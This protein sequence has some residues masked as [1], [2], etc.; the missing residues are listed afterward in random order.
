M[1]RVGFAFRTKNRL[2]FAFWIE[3]DLPFEQVGICLLNRLEFKYFLKSDRFTFR[4]D[5]FMFY[6]NINIIYVAVWKCAYHLY[7]GPV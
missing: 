2:R 5:E 1:N 7:S 3:W 6:V 4:L